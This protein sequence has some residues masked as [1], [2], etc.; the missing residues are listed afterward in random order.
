MMGQRGALMLAISVLCMTSV[1]SAFEWE[2]C[3]DKASSLQTLSEVK[4][5]PEDPIPAGTEAHFSIKGVSSEYCFPSYSFSS[6]SH[7]SQLCPIKKSALSFN[8]F[9]QTSRKP[10]QASH[11]LSS[12]RV[13]G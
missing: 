10:F 13:Q 6:F 11:C 12:V 7:V 4:I 3:G 9:I 8:D 2:Y 1:V 5:F